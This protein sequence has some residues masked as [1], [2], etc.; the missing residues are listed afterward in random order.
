M[1]RHYEAVSYH[2]Y[3]SFYNIFIPHTYMIFMVWMNYNSI[4][5]I[6]NQIH[7]KKGNQYEN[8]KDQSNQKNGKR[9]HRDVRK[10]MAGICIPS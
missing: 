8:D 4:Q 3:S 5:I 9:R 6:Q 7:T 1:I 10:R 2:Y